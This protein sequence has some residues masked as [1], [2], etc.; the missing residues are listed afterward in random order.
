MVAAVAHDEYVGRPLRDL[1]AK[2][3]PGG[4][5]IDVKSRFDRKALEQAGVRLW[6]L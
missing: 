3:Q 2:L 1:L 4:T 6:R 5:F